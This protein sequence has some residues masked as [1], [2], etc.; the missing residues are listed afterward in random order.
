MIDKPSIIVTSLGRTGTKF[1]SLLFK[2]IIPDCSSFHEPDIIQYFGTSNNRIKPFIARVRDAGI[3]NMVFLKL[4]GKWSLIKVSDARLREDVSEEQA[5]KEVLWQR[6]GFINSK[7][8][9]IYVESNAGYYGL[10]P[11][12][13]KVYTHHRAIY[14]VRDGREWVS[15][16]MNVGELYGKKGLRKIFSHKVPSA[17][18]FPNDP[19]YERWQ[20]IS[21]FEKLCWAWAKLNGYALN[22]I[23]KNPYAHMFH[24]E[25]IFSKNKS[26]QVLN[27]LVTFATSLPGIEPK[28]IGKTDGWLDRKIH[29]SSNEF[30]AWKK[31]T[32]DQRS[33]FGK[34]CGP[35]MEELG[36]PF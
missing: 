26:Y 12:L 24:F 32:I 31:W 10:I 11:I 17:S 27:D 6:T 30:Q 14:I 35:L 29:E 18:E 16:A 9:N 20:S 33:Q 3:Y 7:P 34:I 28:H 5:I 1:F 8:G 4:L 2:E 25:E 36:Y 19:L 15:S 22:A 13:N 23:V 21:Q